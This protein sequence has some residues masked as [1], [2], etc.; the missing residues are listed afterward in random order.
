MEDGLAEA[1]QILL[2]K[3]SEARPQLETATLKFC[4]KLRRLTH[5]VPEH[6][7]ASVL[8]SRKLL[9]RPGKTRRDR[10]SLKAVAEEMWGSDV[11]HSLAR[12]AA[13]LFEGPVDGDE[14]ISGRNSATSEKVSCI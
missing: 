13:I 3:S 7:E 8:R 12:H 2:R 11:S 5:E 10:R 1:T 6:I 4:R 14:G 9:G